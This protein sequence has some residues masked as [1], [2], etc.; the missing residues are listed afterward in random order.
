[1]TKSPKTKL[2]TSFKEKIYFSPGTKR[3]F[4]P[5]KE[6]KSFE[7]LDNKSERYKIRVRG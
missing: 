1:M 7:T 2:E 5:K 6:R 4:G 3:L